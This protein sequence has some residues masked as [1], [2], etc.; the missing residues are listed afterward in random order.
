MGDHFGQNR[1]GDFGRVMAPMDRP[2]G[3][4]AGDGILFHT[5]VA[6]QIATP[7]MR[8]SRPQSSDIKGRSVQNVARISCLIVV[9]M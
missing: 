2:T 5:H 4:D 3:R 7:R 8:T 1:G 6:Q 9:I